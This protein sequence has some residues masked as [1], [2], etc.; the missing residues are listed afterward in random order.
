MSDCAQCRRPLGGQRRRCRSCGA[1]ESCCICPDEPV[2]NYRADGT[3]SE[4]IHPFIPFSPAELG[5]DPEDYDLELWENQ[6]R[7]RS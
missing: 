3:V 4:V 5:L 1:C 6:T 2:L 7:R